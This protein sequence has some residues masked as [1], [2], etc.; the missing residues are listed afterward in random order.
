MD[1]AIEVSHGRPDARVA[2]A[3][4][5]S[6]SAHAASHRTWFAD[7]PAEHAPGRTL[8]EEVQRRG[9]AF[10]RRRTAGITIVFGDS[11]RPVAVVRPRP[12]PIIVKVAEPEEIRNCQLFDEV[13]QAGAFGKPV[14]LILL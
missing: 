1:V 12:F 13:R 2:A 7:L 10:R 14:R 3:D 4:R 11:E 5:L 8:F 6:R 9:N